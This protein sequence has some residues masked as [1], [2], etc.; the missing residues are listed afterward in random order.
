MRKICVVTGTRAEYGLLYWILAELRDDPDVELQLIVCAAHL[1]PEFGYTVQVIED[2]GFG[3]ADRVDMQVSG[4]TPA[5]IGHS[6]GLGCIGFSE[7]FERLAPDIVVVLGDRYEI[8]AAAQ[9]ALIA[10][11]PL[12]HI[13]GGERTEGAI[14]DAIR[15]AITKMSHLHFVAAEPY[16]TR[17]IQLGENPDRVFL[18]GAPGLD[19]FRRL[20]LLDRKSLGESVGFDLSGGVFA[21]TY[22]PAT[23]ANDSAVAAASELLAALDSYPDHKALITAPSADAN[24]LNLLDALRTY[25]KAHPDRA[26]FVESLNQMRYLSLLHIADA[27]IGN[28]SSG[29]IEAPSVPVPTVNIGPR[30]DGRLRAPSI[31]DCTDDREA[32]RA[33]IE[34]ALSDKF[35]NGLAGM[36]SPF[37]DGDA[38]SRIVAELKSAELEGLLIKRFHDF[39]ASANV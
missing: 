1:S 2:D 8:L 25:A 17:V 12:A 11:I 26:H 22:H 19:N 28:S 31:I 24:A 34:T 9:C 3:I 39:P 36:T 13:H 33:A 4:D 10:R 20:K 27:V 35:R 37:G 16:R 15:H 6:L 29:I 5:A 38:S 32:I 18:V 14:D 23:L 21:V 7:S 30:Q